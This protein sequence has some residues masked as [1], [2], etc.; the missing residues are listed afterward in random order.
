MLL[1]SASRQVLLD[2]RINQLLDECKTNTAQVSSFMNILDLIDSGT[3]RDDIN[4]LMNTSR[5]EVDGLY[6]KFLNVDLPWSLP[7]DVDGYIRK[8][9]GKKTTKVIAQHLKK[10]EPYIRSRASKLQIS[11]RLTP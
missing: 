8:N 4:M 7:A 10:E 3:T 9:A 5:A 11:L 2:T 1:K 6:K